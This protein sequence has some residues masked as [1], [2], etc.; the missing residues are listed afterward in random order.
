MLA[1]CEL[2]ER[3][4][5]IHQANLQPYQALFDLWTR[6]SRSRRATTIEDYWKVCQAFAEFVKRKPLTDITR[7]DLVSF[8][9]HLL[10]S[11]QS[12]LTATRKVGILKSL[13][14]T[15]I[16]HELIAINPA[17]SFRS[18]TRQLVKQRVAFTCDD[19]SRIFGSAIY[20]DNLRPKSGGRDAAYWLPCLHYM[21]A[22]ELKNW[23]SC[24]QATSSMKK[25]WATI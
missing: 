10:E 23:H 22:Q 17:E 25:D 2:D 7:K 1:D 13:F 16:N 11:G 6:G 8:H 24:W 9:D 5:Q 4:Y 15:A 3:P 21:Q 18:Q 12:A 14:V 19:L 20:A